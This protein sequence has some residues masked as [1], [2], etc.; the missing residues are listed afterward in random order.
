L[1]PPDPTAKDKFDIPASIF[2]V[3]LDEA[4]APAAARGT[5][6][7]GGGDTG[8]GGGAPVSS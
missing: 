8:S 4:V 5:G 6:E 1:D 7:N 3:W 2:S